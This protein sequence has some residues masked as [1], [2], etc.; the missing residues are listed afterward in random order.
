MPYT[1]PFSWFC[2]IR[3][4]SSSF[5]LRSFSAFFASNSYRLRSCRSVAAR[6]ELGCFTGAPVPLERDFAPADCLAM[7]VSL[8]LSP[9]AAYLITPAAPGG[10]SLT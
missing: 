7:S 10:P 4:S 6:V 9:P 2:L 3:R 1:V 5:S 8:S